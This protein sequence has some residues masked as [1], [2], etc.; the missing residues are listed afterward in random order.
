MRIP[1][2]HILT[3]KIEDPS[4]KPNNLDRTMNIAAIGDPDPHIP[5][6]RDHDDQDPQRNPESWIQPIIK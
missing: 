6:Q 4:E 3:P 5:P 2:T 1:I